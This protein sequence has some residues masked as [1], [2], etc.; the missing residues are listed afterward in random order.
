MGE[1]K[2]IEKKDLR[3]ARRA[4]G[5]TQRELGE[6]IGLAQV[7]ISL[8]ERG[9][10]TLLQHQ[11]AAVDSILGEIEWEQCYMKRSMASLG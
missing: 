1:T 11:R 9:K 5:L 8:V 4:A 6:L 3:T 2:N 7:H 10:L